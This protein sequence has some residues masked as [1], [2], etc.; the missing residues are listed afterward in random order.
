MLTIYHNPRCSKSREVLELTQQFA[1][2]RQLALSIVDY[3]KMPLTLAQLGELHQALQ[4]EKIV[5]VMDMMRENEALFS[6]LGLKDA[7]NEV[8]LN[9]IAAHP[10]LLQRPI[11]RY[12]H[13]AVIARPPE[14]VSSILQIT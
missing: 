7:G 9:A 14:L 6:P 11:V 4:S 10:E 2:Q 8:L 5:N 12:N 13:R 3:Q 1:E